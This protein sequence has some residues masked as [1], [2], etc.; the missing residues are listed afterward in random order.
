MIGRSQPSPEVHRL[1]AEALGVALQVV[2]EGDHA[3]TALDAE[4]VMPLAVA[5][6]AAA[7]FLPV[8]RVS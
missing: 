3:Q 8:R 1:T 2:G 5:H 7:G 4:R 6:L